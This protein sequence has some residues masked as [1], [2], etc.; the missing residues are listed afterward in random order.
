MRRPTPFGKYYLLDRVN[1]GGMAEVFR[2]KATGVEGFEKLVAIKRILPNIAEDDEFITM[3][4]DEAKI[5]VQLNHANIAQIYDLGK[6]DDSYFIAM[7]FVSGKDLRTIF[8]R[9]RKRGEVLPIPM[10][11]YT[12]A[13]ICEGL[14]YAH[15]KK[16]PQGRDLNIVHRDVSPQNILVS[17]EGE[18]KLI[19]FGIAKAANKASKTQA[20]ILKGKFGYMSPEQVR[21][22]PID[23]RSDVFSVGIVLYE[24]LT[25]ERLFVGESDFSTLEKVRNVEIMPPTTYNRRIPEELEAI[26]LKALSRE[27]EDRFQ[28]A[29]ELQE[30]LTRFLILSGNMFSRKDLAHFMKTSFAEDIQREHAALEQFKQTSP[31]A[32]PSPVQIAAQTARPPPPPPPTLRSTPA[33]EDLA[34]RVYDGPPPGA[35]PESVESGRVAVPLP[36]SA[37]DAPPP[38]PISLNTNFGTAAPLYR[39]PL[40]ESVR[41]R[42]VLAVVTVA[43]LAAAAAVLFVYLRTLETGRPAQ[44]ELVTSPGADVR[45]CEGK[46]CKP[47]GVVP[48][49]GKLVSQHLSGKFRLVI[50]KAGCTRREVRASLVSRKPNVSF[51]RSDLAAWGGPTPLRRAEVPPGTY[52]IEVSK[53]DYFSRTVK[54]SVASGAERQEKVIL[55]AKAVELAVETDPKGAKVSVLDAASGNVVAKPRKKTPLRVRLQ[56]ESLHASFRVE[57]RKKGYETWSGP[58]VFN[59][60]A[61]QKLSPAPIELVK[62]SRSVAARKK[63]R[64]PEPVVATPPPPAEPQFGT[65]DINLKG[66]WAYVHINGRNTGKATPI[67]GM[68]LKVGR[69]RVTLV[70][71]E[72][73]IQDEFYVDIAANQ[74]TRAIRDYRARE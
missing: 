1:V 4:I 68:K 20:G 50:E 45:I 72:L 2:A 30:E 47:L 57:I 69:H 46:D 32:A 21:G 19:D 48:A 61:L 35:R 11:C 6:I 51:L 40:A 7:E 55:P 52:E 39:M 14:D 74:P 73:G 44:I 22:L 70:R 54:V 59:G 18:V 71:E 56:R 42:R 53:K 16:D 38:A 27:P 49:S 66:A 28:Y 43:S 15:R 8:E 64:K 36:A 17:Y 12:V 41:R 24:L 31:G 3:F 29:S 26:V 65:L 67:T 9:A 10:S 13:R 60:Q 5:A 63:K 62:K 25:G 58:V 33:A 34:T 23:R 37:S